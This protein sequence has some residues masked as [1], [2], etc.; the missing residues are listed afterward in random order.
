MAIFYCKYCSFGKF[1]EGVLMRVLRE[2]S[3]VAHLYHWCDCCHE[4]IS[5]GEMYEGTVYVT[6]GFIWVKKQHIKPH[7]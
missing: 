6:D 5:P 3:H 4:L 2:C 7:C 1:T